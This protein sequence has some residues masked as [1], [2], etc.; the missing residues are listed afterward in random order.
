VC[1]CHPNDD[2][3]FKI[4]GSW[5]GWPGQKLRHFLQNNQSKK[6]WSTVS[7]EALLLQKKS[8]YSFQ[9]VSFILL[10]LNVYINNIF[11]GATVN[12]VVFLI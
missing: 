1:I 8:F 3:E 9:S 7:S 12:K 6:G 2:R 5:S 4:G 11:F 10:L